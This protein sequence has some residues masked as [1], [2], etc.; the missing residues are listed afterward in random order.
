MD[1]G[2]LDEAIA[3]LRD[4]I[5]NA[6]KKIGEDK[7]AK[8]LHKEAQVNLIRTLNTQAELSPENSEVLL[9]LLADVL[10]EDQSIQNQENMKILIKQLYRLR[11]M[12]ELLDAALRM[13]GVFPKSTFPLEW[14][15]KVYL[16]WVT[17]TL[18]IP[19]G[20]ME[21]V[22]SLTDQIFPA[23]KKISF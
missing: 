23:L 18:E 7:D 12:S 2:H 21:Q 10:S 6:S 20:K 5:E 1:V 16:E 22:M 15:C 13:A 11:R 19:S 14:V 3:V 9:R 4:M 8:V 17:D